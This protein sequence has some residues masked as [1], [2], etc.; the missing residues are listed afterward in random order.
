MTCNPSARPEL[1]LK[2]NIEQTAFF[3]QSNLQIE[4]KAENCIFLEEKLK[5]ARI[6]FLVNSKDLNAIIRC[7]RRLADLHFYK[8]AKSVFS[9]GI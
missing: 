7:G 3:F 5:E 6:N 4:G 1:E 8:A 2:K 9:L